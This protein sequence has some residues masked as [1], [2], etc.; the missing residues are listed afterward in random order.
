[1]E[2]GIDMLRVKVYINQEQIEYLEIRNMKRKSQ[3]YIEYRVKTDISNFFTVLHRRKDGWKILL[4]KV[5]E[6]INNQ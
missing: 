5:L 6:A 1:M 4:I 2:E 3:G